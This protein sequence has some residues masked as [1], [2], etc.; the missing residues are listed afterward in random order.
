[1]SATTPP[2]RLTASGDRDGALPL[3]RR[4]GRRG[5]TARRNPFDAE[6]KRMATLHSL[7][8]RLLVLVKG[9]AETVLP[10]C[11]RIPGRGASSPLTALWQRS[12]DDRH[13]AMAG[14]VA[15]CNGVPSIKPTPTPSC[16][17]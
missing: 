4:A 17:Y 2:H 7:D 11:D 1:M 13:R 15:P 6:R 5:R 16:Y 14:Q 8:G 3:C 9:A 12:F 10:L